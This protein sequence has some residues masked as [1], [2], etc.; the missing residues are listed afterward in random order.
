M[1]RLVNLKHR[2]RV[3]GTQKKPELVFTSDVRSKKPNPFTEYF[4]KF[5]CVLFLPK[6]NTITNSVLK[7]GFGHFNNHQSDIH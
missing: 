4:F 3:K 7:A 6:K 1:S 5:F 2:V